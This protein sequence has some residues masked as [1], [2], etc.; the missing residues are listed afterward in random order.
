MIASIS[1]FGTVSEQDKLFSCKLK[2]DAADAKSN[3]AVGE[4]NCFV[5]QDWKTGLKHLAK[6]S[7][8]KYLMIAGIEI[9]DPEEG[10][11]QYELAD[12]WWEVSEKIAKIQGDNVK[13]HAA[14]WYAKSIPSLT[15]ISKRRA[16][17]RCEIAAN[18]ESGE[19]SNKKKY[20]AKIY[21]NCDNMFELYHNDKLIVS[22]DNAMRGAEV[23]TGDLSVSFGDYLVVKATNL[24]E[25][26]GFSA[27]LALEN[28]NVGTP[29]LEKTWKAF[30]P[31][32][33]EKWYL[34]K[35]IKASKS[36]AA[37]LGSNQRWCNGIIMK[38]G[39]VCKSIWGG[40]K[41]LVY[42]YLKVDKKILQKK[43]S[44]AD[45]LKKT[46]GGG[47]GGGWPGRGGR[48]GRRR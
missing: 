36:E 8:A 19:T 2:I 6:G 37:S 29:T 16:E 44:L 14:K 40:E 25:G 5:K 30:T 4:Y 31:V 48:G 17:T 23:Q 18:L 27:V 39:I 41:D 1:F 11:T 47:R 24:G 9:G 10:K 22:C 42:L 28:L 3:L 21:A 26:N 33:K 12:A 43:Q 35:K 34:S 15:G 32:N 38:T 46:F 7:N 45:I 20:P 13:V